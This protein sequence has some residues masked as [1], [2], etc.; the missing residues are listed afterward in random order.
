MSAGG[1]HGRLTFSVCSTPDS[2]RKGE[3]LASVV[4]CQMHRGIAL[5]DHLIA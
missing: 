5:F 4:R 2:D 1:N 3:G